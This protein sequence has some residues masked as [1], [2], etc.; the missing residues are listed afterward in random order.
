ML[1]KIKFSED[2]MWLNQ[3]LISEQPD[4]ADIGLPLGNQSSQ[5]FALLYLN[6]VDRFIKKKLKIYFK[7]S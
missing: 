2:E 7:I 1:K 5:W 6:V 4:D 3:K